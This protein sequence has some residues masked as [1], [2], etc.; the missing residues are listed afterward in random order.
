MGERLIHLTEV[1]IIELPWDYYILTSTLSVTEVE[2][3]IKNTCMSPG[4]RIA[5]TTGIRRLL[6]ACL[7]VPNKYMTVGIAC[8]RMRNIVN[9]VVTTCKKISKDSCYK[10][11]E[12]LAQ[13]VYCPPFTT[14][15]VCDDL[16]K[17]PIHELTT[18][19][20]S[21]EDVRSLLDSLVIPVNDHL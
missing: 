20:G 1:Y 13:I 19:V 14:L 10:I 6:S 17:C 18:I 7:L 12:L 5:E 15:G 3:F 21:T 4:V 8:N 2:L 9:S 11:L 16:V